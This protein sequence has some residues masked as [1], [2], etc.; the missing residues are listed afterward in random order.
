MNMNNMNIPT[1]TF[2]IADFP[3]LP[4]IPAILYGKPSDKVYL[5]LHGKYGRK[6][7]A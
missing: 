5:Y 3:G 1:E 4:G 2:R 6:E 7:E